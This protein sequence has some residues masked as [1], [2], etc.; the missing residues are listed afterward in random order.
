M[1]QIA[2][3]KELRDES[4]DDNELQTIYQMLKSWMNLENFSRKEKKKPSL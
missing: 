1:N 2:I 3:K 4:L